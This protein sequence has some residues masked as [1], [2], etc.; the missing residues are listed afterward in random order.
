MKHDHL[1][2]EARREILRAKRNEAFRAAAHATAAAHNA[3]R[4]AHKAAL[5]AQDI[6]KHTAVAAADINAVFKSRD[7]VTAAQDAA[8]QAASLDYKYGGDE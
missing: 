5:A 2:L 4:R 6:Y 1:T 8:A 3:T 7:A